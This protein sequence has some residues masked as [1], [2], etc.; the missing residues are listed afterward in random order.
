M[1][2]LIERQWSDMLKVIS[3][4][5]YFR[6][7]STMQVL[8]TQSDRASTVTLTTL[9]RSFSW[10]FP[11]PLREFNEILLLLS[12]WTSILRENWLTSRVI[13]LPELTTTDSL[14]TSSL[15]PQQ[16]QRTW[17]LFVFNTACLEA[18]LQRTSLYNT[19]DLLL[20]QIFSYSF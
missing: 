6:N 17:D 16:L 14:Q 20:K 3:G 15:H 8:K 18:T 4:E 10:V 12:T 9:F 11:S 2:V 13:H 5:F 19:D 7:A 1:S